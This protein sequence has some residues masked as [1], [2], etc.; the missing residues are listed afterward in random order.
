MTTAS[1]INR[2]ASRIPSEI[3]VR[4]PVRLRGSRKAGTPLA[5]AS[6][7]VA[8]EQP[9]ANALSRRMIPIASL[10]W[11]GARVRPMCAWVWELT[12]P[13][14]IT[15]T[16]LTTN[17]SAGAISRRSDSVIPNMLT[18]V[19]RTRPTTETSSR[20]LDSA[21]KALPRLAAPAAR[22]TATVST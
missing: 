20:W 19:S 14:T 9:V 5:V 21:G 22:L 13:I 2:I 12:S 8:A 6:T 15:A 3:S 17:R 11:K 1:P 7:P 4:C 18:A 10:A 16:V